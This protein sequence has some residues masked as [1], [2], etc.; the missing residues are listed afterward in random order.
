M[1]KKTVKSGIFMFLM[2]TLIICT[3]SF[4]NV[5]ATE[6]ASKDINLK[7][8]IEV[9]GSYAN[10]DGTCNVSQFVNGSGKL[11]LAADEGDYVFIYEIVK[12]KAK[13]KLKL[14]KMFPL[15]GAAIGDED[16]CYYL[17][18]GFANEELDQKK[19]TV[20]IAKYDK[21][22]TL[23]AS[24][25]DDGSSSLASYFDNR[26]YTAEP[27]DAGDCSIAINGDYIA[28]NYARSMYSGH[29]SNSVFMINRKTM[30]K[31]D[32]GV[33]YNSHS[34]AQRI[35][36]FGT[37][38]ASAS[39]GDCYPRAFTLSVTSPQN[40]QSKDY[41]LFHFWVKKG[42]LD[43]WDMYTV[44]DN[45]AH[46]GNVVNLKDKYV[47]LVGTSVK[48][49]DEKAENQNEQIFIQIFNPEKNADSAE[50]YVTKGARKGL[51]GGNGD[52]KVTDY[53]VKWLTSYS[54]AYSFGNVTA[55][56]DD[57]GNTVI[58]YE[59]YKNRAY[60]GVY[61]I[62]VD[63]N[64]NVTTKKTV[65]SKKAFLTQNVPPVFADGT[66]YWFGNRYGS[67]NDKV[68]LYSLKY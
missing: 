39:E 34:F 20:N 53:G 21:K 45:F 1:K 7:K 19:N 68:Y 23:V 67:D 28:V 59:L 51:S 37:G 54:S 14:K 38:F 30:K 52:E 18:T 29:Q 17:M 25:Y 6:K 66:V 31:V 10:W 41:D 64:G 47:A 24:V 61:M 46:M 49:L 15:F 62:V 26:F 42:S 58:L 3:C 36:P 13:L 4:T 44:N 8:E 65:F 2:L 63:I 48:A 27:F 9:T 60:K 40:S 50:A 56:A 32:P 22:G 16:G 57:D 55:A 5:S 11:C 12:N 35:V 33:I 43:Q